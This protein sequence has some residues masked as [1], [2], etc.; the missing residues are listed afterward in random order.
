[1]DDFELVLVSST[2][3]HSIGY[4]LQSQTLRIK[5]R[6]GEIY[7]YYNVPESVHS[8]LMNAS[9][10]GRY[11]SCNIARCYRYKRIR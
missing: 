10:K 11:H 3:L 1:M 2:N 6:G 5:F 9:S 8:A 7:D 4:D